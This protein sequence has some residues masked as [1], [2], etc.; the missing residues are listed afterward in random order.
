MLIQDSILTV[1]VLDVNNVIQTVSHVTPKVNA[2][3]AMAIH[4]T[5]IIPD[6]AFAL[7]NI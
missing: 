6:N 3:N 7:T 4:L 1:L 2:I 5:T